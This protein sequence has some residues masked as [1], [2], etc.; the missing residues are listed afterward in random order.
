MV[1]SVVEWDSAWQEGQTAADISCVA[2]VAGRSLYHF[3]LLLL[4]HFSIIQEYPQVSS[5]GMVVV[6]LWGHSLDGFGT[7]EVSPNRQFKKPAGRHYLLFPGLFLP[8]LHSMYLVSAS[9]GK[10]AWQGNPASC[11]ARMPWRH[12]LWERLLTLLIL[13]GDMSICHSIVFP[14]FHCYR[15]HKWPSWHFGR[16]CTFRLPREADCT[17][18]NRNSLLPSMGGWKNHLQQNNQSFSFI[19]HSLVGNSLTL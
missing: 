13:R 19:C 10:Q 4:R 6:W 2:A 11:G 18:R 16:S 1:G 12:L 14:V 8:L 7:L 3:K 17:Q 15:R 5:M 9:P